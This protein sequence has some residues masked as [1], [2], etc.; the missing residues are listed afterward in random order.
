MSGAEYPVSNKSKG[1]GLVH[2]DWRRRSDEA[3]RQATRSRIRPLTTPPSPGTS[4]H[5]RSSAC[6]Q[7]A[8]LQLAR[9][10]LCAPAALRACSVRACRRRACSLQL[11]CSQLASLQLACSLRACSLRPGSFARAFA[12]PG[13]K[14]R[15]SRRVAPTHSPAGGTDYDG[16]WGGIACK[17]IANSSDRQVPGEAPGALERR[18]LRFPPEKGLDLL[19]GQPPALRTAAKERQALPRAF[20]SRRLPNPGNLSDICSP[21]APLFGN[22]QHQHSGKECAAPAPSPARPNG[23]GAPPLLLRTNSTACCPGAH[24]RTR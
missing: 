7:L 23:P 8:S 12:S 10:Q 6:V 3:G 24:T 14:R 13:A 17:G 21:R 19:L 5:P 18:H 1:G 4:L 11:A 22:R 20:E 16:G 2:A 15:E 9:L